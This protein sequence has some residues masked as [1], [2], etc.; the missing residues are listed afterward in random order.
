[1]QLKVKKQNPDGEVR[2]ETKG[3][4]AEIRIR[5]DFMR[6]GKEIIELCFRGG[7]SSGVISIGAKEF[8]NVANEVG[9]R[10]RLVKSIKIIKD[11]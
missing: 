5:E 8:E 1:M 7:S 11:E 6:P 3:K 10:V 4:I 2:L 9:S